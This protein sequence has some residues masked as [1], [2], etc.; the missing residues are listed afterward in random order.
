MGKCADES[1]CCCATPADAD[2]RKRIV[3]TN[4]NNKRV[5]K[6]KKIPTLTNSVI[7]CDVLQLLVSGLFNGEAKLLWTGLLILRGKYVFCKA[8]LLSG[9]EQQKADVML[10]PHSRLLCFSQR[11]AAFDQHFTQAMAPNP[12]SGCLDH[13]FMQA[14]A[15]KKRPQ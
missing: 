7:H 8:S 14:T 4:A 5:Q 9:G 1:C 6:C 10:P 11:G 13:R 2:Q 12:E 3:G 15:C